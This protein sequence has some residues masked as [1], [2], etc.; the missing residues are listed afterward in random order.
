MLA[1][2][3]EELES[4]RDGTK[5]PAKSKELALRIARAVSGKLVSWSEVGE[6]GSPVLINPDNVRRL[7]YPVLS[8]CY[9]VISGQAPSDIRDDASS[10]EMDDVLKDFEVSANGDRPGLVRLEEA[11]KN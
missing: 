7:H 9:Y 2:E 5:T 10:G 1:E 11:E 6:D 8:R 4:Y 3:V